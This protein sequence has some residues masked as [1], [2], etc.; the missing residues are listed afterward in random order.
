ME[1]IYK[2]YRDSKSC[3]YAIVNNVNKKFYIGSTISSKQRW[4]T[5]RRSLKINQHDNSYLQ[6]AWNKYGE[7]S[8]IFNIT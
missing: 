8:F 5:H 4:Y 7:D 3:V 1:K 2:R 6:N